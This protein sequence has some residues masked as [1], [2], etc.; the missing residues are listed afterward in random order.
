MSTAEEFKALFREWDLNGNGYI[1]RSELATLFKKLDPNFSIFDLNLL[2]DACDK[3]GDGRLSYNEFCDTLWPL[4]V[5]KTA[6][7]KDAEPSNK[8]A[9]TDFNIARMRAAE[10]RCE[11][12][13]KKAEAAAGADKKEAET[14]A[15]PAEAAKPP[16]EAAAEAPAPA[17]VAEEAVAPKPE[18]GE[19]TEAPGRGHREFSGDTGTV[20]TSQAGLYGQVA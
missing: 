12:Q 5:Q 1:E 18:E 3:N 20:T 11:E 7:D 17:P 8:K 9:L 15:A 16:E 10:A 19:A 4:V 14:E 13:A 6:E 2:M